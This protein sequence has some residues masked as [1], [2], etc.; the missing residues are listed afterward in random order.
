MKARTN[1]R[2]ALVERKAMMRFVSLSIA[3]A[4]LLTAAVVA[5][6]NTGST[7]YITGV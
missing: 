2:H 4:L 6:C 1:T 7:L 5:A 3:A